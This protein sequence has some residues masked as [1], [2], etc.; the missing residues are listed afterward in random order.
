MNYKKIFTTLRYTCLLAVIVLGLVTIIGTGGSSD[1]G[2]SNGSDNGSEN[3]TANGRDSD[4]DNGNGNGFVGE[5]TFTNSIGM[6]FVYIEPGTFI[7]GSPEDEPGRYDD[8]TQHQVT[9]TQGYYMQTTPVTQ[10]Q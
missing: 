9:L 4:D 5:D 6:D 3:G 10:G 7:M 2:S 8:E 1:N